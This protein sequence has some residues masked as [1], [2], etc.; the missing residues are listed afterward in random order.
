MWLTASSSSALLGCAGLASLFVGSLYLAPASVR[1]RAHD[2]DVQISWRFRSTAV[3]CIVS[4]L[5]LL[6]WKTS[7]DL[8]LGNG[9]SLLEWIGV[10][11]DGFLRAVSLPLC[12]II[13]L[14]T[15]P[16]LDMHLSYQREKAAGQVDGF[17]LSNFFPNCPS[18][19]LQQIRN[20]IAAPFAEE[21]VFRGCMAALLHAAKWSHSS[22]IRVSP[23]FFGLA[24]LH[25][26][27]GM[28]MRGTPA[29]Q[30]MLVSLVQMTYTSLFGALE[31]M[32]FLRTGHL[33]SVFLIHS[34]CNLMGL[35]PFGF[36]DKSHPNHIHRNSI[37]SAYVFGI[38]VFI[39]GFGP[40]TNPELYANKIYGK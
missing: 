29:K 35:P 19:P 32:F 34:W 37:I 40:L 36:L 25:H 15:G 17:S 8:Q 9:P 11:S 23:L 5:L 6:L 1:R 4:P 14:F 24:H 20:L 39:L 7:S 22:I 13:I 16:L 26:C 27:I 21:L 2:D 33:V 31:M 18:S 28:I 30:A 3:T 10:R 38:L 12:L